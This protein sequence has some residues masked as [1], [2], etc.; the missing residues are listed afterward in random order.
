MTDLRAALADALGPLYRVERE[1]RPVGDCR[2]FVAREVPT[3]P[4]LLVKLLPARLSL[5]VD[6]GLFERE[7]LL[8]ADRLRHPQFVAPRGAGRAGAFVYHTR[9]FVAGTTLRAWLMRHG[10]LPL[11]RTVEIL[12]GV[13]AAL[14]HAHA[15]S[16]AHGDLKPENVL[17][18]DGGTLVADTGVVDAVGH[19]LTGGAAVAGAALC[20]P[21]YVAP[22]RRDGGAPGPRD[23]MFAVGGLAHDM[24]TGQPPAPGALAACWETGGM[25]MGP[26]SAAS[27]AARITADAAADGSAPGAVYAL[28]NRISGNAVAVFR[29][30]AD[31]T[32]VAAGSVATGGAGTGSGLGSQGAL[33]LSDD[34]RWLFAVNAGSN[35]VSAFRVGP[36]GLSLTSRVG[37]G[38]TR[39][40]S[41]TV[42]GSLL[43]VLN[44]GGDGNISGFT[45]GADG[46]LAAIRGSSRILSGAAVGPAQVAFSSDG[47]WLVVTEKTTNQ[48]DLY[49]VGPDGMA[50][51]PTSYASAGGTPFGFGFGHRDELF[52]SEAAG[53]ASSYVLGGSG[54][55]T[56][57][58]GA[59]G[60]HQGA[61]RWLVVTK[62]GPSP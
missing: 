20:A 32:L 44:G 45:V 30:A 56:A 58:S 53:S 17:L 59:V 34:G 26:H 24:L 57:V 41:L 35:E 38:G 7:L 29:R 54:G 36:A 31:G 15:A 6:S 50:T 9:A 22:E 18:A 55:L 33:V 60:P 21:P 1:V 3:G 8:V 43:Y 28:T 16:V 52:V 27:L 14:A 42:H 23:D 51:G 13:L 37:S 47:R 10:E 39:P 40:I 61:P 2:L 19:S 12:R 25:P 62:D 48:L 5:A 4:E 11:R 49:A 46:V